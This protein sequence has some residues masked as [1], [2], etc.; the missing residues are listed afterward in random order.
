M[1][2]PLKLWKE[3][4]SIDKASKLTGVLKNTIRDRTCGFVDINCTKSGRAPLFTKDEEDDIVAHIKATATFGYGYSRAQLINLLT[5][6]ALYLKKRL[7]TNKPIGQ[8]KLS[9][10]ISRH[11]E[12]KCTKPQRL[13]MLRAKSCTKEKIAAYF[14]ELEINLKQHDLT[15]RPERIFNI[16]ETGFSPEHTPPKVVVPRD[17]PFQSICS[18]SSFTTT[19]HLSHVQV[20]LIYRDSPL[21]C[22]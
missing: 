3:G 19:I 21:F 16:D 10:F 1:Q 13:C 18:P 20:L 4:V 8:K 2:R 22:F 17:I 9:K 7:N 5:D 15:N 14:S 11:S 12:L 6:T